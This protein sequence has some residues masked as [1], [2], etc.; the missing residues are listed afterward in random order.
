MTDEHATALR[1]TPILISLG[2][3]LV[4]PLFSVPV[5]AAVHHLIPKLGAVEARVVTEGAIWLYAA[6]VLAIA[7]FWERRTLASIGLRRPTRASLGFG[8]VGAIAIAGAGALGS[9]VVYTLLHLPEHA[10][11]Q[12]AAMVGGSVIYALCLAVR[13]GVVEEIFYRGLAIEQL[14]AL[15]GRRWFAAVVATAVFVL[16]HK[17]H[18]DWAQLVPIAAVAIVLAAL[19]LRRHDLWANIIAHIAVDAVGLVT[20]ALQA[21]H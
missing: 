14:T 10:D 18:F 12:A 16:I 17:L 4:Y 11:A 13:A 5:Q 7:L 21:H 15:T 19:Y 6:I 9:Y 3:I 1:R 20:L 8:V 2:L